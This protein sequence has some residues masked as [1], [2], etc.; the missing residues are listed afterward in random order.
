[1]VIAREGYA[2]LQAVIGAWV[3]KASFLTLSVGKEAF[4]DGR[5]RN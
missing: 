1:M 2:G 5:Q 3:V 4:T